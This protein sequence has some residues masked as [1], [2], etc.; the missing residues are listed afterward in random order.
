[1]FMPRYK[2]IYEKKKRYFVQNPRKPG[3]ENG[4]DPYRCFSHDPMEYK[5]SICIGSPMCHCVVTRA[6]LGLLRTRVSLITP[7][8]RVLDGW[9]LWG[10]V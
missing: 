9:A 7:R 8:N 2:T 6:N 4:I 5:S 3:K 10:T 1:M